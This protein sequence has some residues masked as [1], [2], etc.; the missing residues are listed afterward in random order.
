MNE[1]ATFLNLFFLHIDTCFH[2]LKLVLQ[3]FSTCVLIIVNAPHIFPMTTPF[4]CPK[5][6]SL[7]VFYAL[8]RLI[9]VATHTLLDVWRPMEYGW[10]FGVQQ[11]SIVNIFSTRTFSSGDFVATPLSMLWFGLVC[12]YPVLVHAVTK[13]QVTLLRLE[14][15]V[16]SSIYYT[17]SSV[18]PERWQEGCYFCIFTYRRIFILIFVK[19]LL[20]VKCSFGFDCFGEVICL[21]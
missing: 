8:L 4:P 1:K 17:L 3:K 18:T 5:F 9:C 10:L 15:A 20:L 12:L 11:L 14:K 19:P 7:C 13:H 2:F 16:F 6:V 21:Q